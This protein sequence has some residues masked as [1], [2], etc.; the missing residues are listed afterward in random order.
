ML[1]SVAELPK[2]ILILHIFPPS[3]MLSFISCHSSVLQVSD[4][5]F[6]IA[7][8]LL[9]LVYFSFHLSCFSFPIGSF[10]TPL[11]RVSLMSSILFSSP[12]SIFMMIILKSSFWKI[13][14][15]LFERERTSRGSSRG[16][17]RSRLPTLPGMGLN[18]R[19]L[20]S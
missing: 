12:V 13:F 20:R 11:L 7:Y 4:S 9:P 16:R 3:H 10:L 14:N 5:F 8:Y 18:P 1:D 19:T 17:G 15:Y 6:S 2:S